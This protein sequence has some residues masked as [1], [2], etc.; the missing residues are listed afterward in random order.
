[1]CPTSCDKKT[2]DSYCFSVHSAYSRVS[3]VRLDGQ[4]CCTGG[5]H[6]T[7]EFSVR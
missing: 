3:I 4:V 5:K 7:K 1:M 6:K 2:A